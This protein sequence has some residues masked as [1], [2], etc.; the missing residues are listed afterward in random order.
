MRTRSNSEA[1]GLENPVERVILDDNDRDTFIL[2]DTIY[3]HTRANAILDIKIDTKF[4][5]DI[6]RGR[7]EFNKSSR[8]GSSSVS[9]RRCSS[10]VPSSRAC[11][12]RPKRYQC[13]FEGCNKAYSRPSLLEE[14]M[15]SHYGHRPF[16][17]EIEDC[18][19]TFT[20]KGHLTRHMLKHTDEKD[21]P[22]HCSI[23]GKGVNSQ[24]HLKRHEKTHFKSFECTHDGCD[25]SF[26]KHQSLK[27]HMRTVHETQMYQHSCSICGKEFNRPGRLKD[28]V[29]KHHSQIPKL[30]CDF[31]GCY[32]TFHVWSALHFHVKVDH[33]RLVCDICGKKCIGQGGLDN[34]MLIHDEYTAIKLWKCSDCDGKFQRKDDAVKHYAE[35]HPSVELPDELKYEINESEKLKEKTKQSE[36]EIQY[37]MAKKEDAKRV[38]RMRLEAQEADPNNSQPLIE[39]LSRRNIKEKIV[40]RK[41][42]A[43]NLDELV[44]S[45]TSVVSDYGF[46]VSKPTCKKFKT[47]EAQ[48]IPSSP[49]V[50]DL[51]IDNI[52]NRLSCPYTH[53]SRLFRKL[54]D[55]ERHLA[56]HEKQ[57]E[58]MNKRIKELSAESDTKQDKVC[59]SH[60]DYHY[61]EYHNKQDVTFKGL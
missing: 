10:S 55:L 44:D 5:E 36:K 50:L 24:Q 28:H 34:H 33:P 48:R 6:K 1:S 19:Q 39:E 14:H 8:R 12:P 11:S 57:N 18:G 7:L 21:K 49:D 45:D 35:K 2:K 3:P 46:I 15:R 43:G 23:C 16:K 51:I 58:K 40:N 25:E 30:M 54:Y 31:P 53:C 59:E 61:K 60:E 38:K 32:K 27:M 9:N 47:H 52:D 42:K 37:Y 4:D 56:W 20:K 13:D 29:E 41:H 22:L 26:Y 17:C